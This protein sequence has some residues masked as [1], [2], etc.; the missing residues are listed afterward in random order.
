MAV[1][2]LDDGTA[3]VEAVVFGEL[4][5]AKRAIIQE[6]H[7]VILAGRASLDEFSGGVRLTADEL[8]DLDEARNRF[9]KGLRLNINGQADSAKLK[10][11]LGPYG[12][13][14]CAVSIRY[15]N[16]EGECDIRLP[17]SMRVKLSEPLIA[18]LGAWLDE[19]NVEVVY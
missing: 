1:L 17:D 14:K 19:K 13:G 8:Y 18:S 5:N 7:V 16:A 15:R 2:T 11:L 3:R 6:D 4:F 12:G 10:S 9:A